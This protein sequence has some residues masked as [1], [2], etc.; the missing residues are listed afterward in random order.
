[1]ADWTPTTAQV[2]A[3]VADHTQ[4]NEGTHGTTSNVVGNFTAETYPTGTQVTPLITQAETETAPHVLADPS[5]SVEALAN[6]AASR[7]AAMLVIHSF[8]SEQ[9]ENPES[10]EALRQLWLDALGGLDASQG[11]TG[12]TR[13]GIYSIPLRPDVLPDI[14]A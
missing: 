2:A 1:M 11:D 6:L 10:Y 7:R 5:D 12:Q 14:V 4:R 9:L 13:K 8:F 3:I